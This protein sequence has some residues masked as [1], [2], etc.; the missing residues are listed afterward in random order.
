V[1]QALEA[2]LDLQPMALRRASSPVPAIVLCLSVLAAICAATAY[3]VSNGRFA[4]QFWLETASAAIPDPT[5]SATLKDI[6]S[7]Q[8]QNATALLENA[9]VVES[10]TQSSIA[11]Q[12]DLKRIF[13]QLSSLAAR[14]DAI[15]NV[16]TPVTTSTQPTARV[17]AVRPSQ[18][19]PSRIPKPSGPVSVGGAPL[20]TAPMLGSGRG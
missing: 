19:K 9:A 2:E 1:A 14:V 11:Q 8:Q 18:K 3:A 17:P 15:Q 20:R 7:S 12:A 10:L 16:A 6:R 13:D 5:V 4:E